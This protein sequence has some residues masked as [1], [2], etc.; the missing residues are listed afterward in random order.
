M[1]IGRFGLGKHARRAHDAHDL[2]PVQHRHVP[3]HDHDVGVDGADGVER[4]DAVGRLVGRLDAEIGQHHS[5]QPA[6]IGVAV[7]D[8]D[9]K[10][11][12]GLLELLGNH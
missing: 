5:R 10:P 3:I 12:H 1:M 4:G 6:R 7:R 2:A 8:Q 11:F 9:N